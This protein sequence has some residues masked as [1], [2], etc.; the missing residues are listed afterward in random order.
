MSQMWNRRQWNWTHFHSN[1]IVTI[2]NIH[3]IKGTS[4]LP[5]LCARQH[6]YDLNSWSV[7]CT[8]RGSAKQLVALEQLRCLW[9][10]LLH[11]HCRCS[12]A[13]TNADVNLRSIK[14]F[15]RFHSLYSDVEM[16]LFV[17]C[18]PSS[19]KTIS[20]SSPL[21]QSPR[22]YVCCLK[23]Q[24]NNLGLH[25]F[26]DKWI[27]SLLPSAIWPTTHTDLPAGIS[28]VSHIISS[29]R[30]HRTLALFRLLSFPLSPPRVSP[31]VLLYLQP[32]Q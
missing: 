24:Q 15:P 27:P 22:Q 14:R 18:K 16:H 9:S 28:R 21:G 2:S 29:Q 1:L 30:S 20:V 8:N 13:G 4:L 23:C 7:S 19:W 11:I 26:I 32:A 6:H 31:H 10:E 12:A 5:L 17:L 3:I 25:S